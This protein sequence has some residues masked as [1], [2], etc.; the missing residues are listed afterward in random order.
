MNPEDLVHDKKDQ[1]FTF[2]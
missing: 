2:V 1:N